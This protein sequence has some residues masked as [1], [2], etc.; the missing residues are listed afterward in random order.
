MQISDRLLLRIADQLPKPELPEEPEQTEI[1]PV[2]E[3]EDDPY[4]FDWLF[5]THTIREQDP[6]VIKQRLDAENEEFEN[7]L[8]EIRY[9]SII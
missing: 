4:V 6:E 8:N 3:E 7:N 1:D 2:E 5:N 9:S